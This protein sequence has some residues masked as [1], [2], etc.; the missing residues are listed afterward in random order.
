MKKYGLIILLF[1]I[2]IVLVF[3][4][5]KPQ[6]FIKTGNLYISEIVASNSYTYKDEDGEYSDYIELYND[7]DFSIDLNGYYLTDNLYDIKKWAIGD[8]NIDAHEYLIIFASGKK[9]CDDK[10]MCHT[11]YKLKS[12]GE[13]ITLIDNTGN[14]ISRV[15]YP[16]M[17]NDISYSYSKKSYILTKPTPKEKNS[18]E[19]IK[20]IDI[21]KYQ[22]K[23]NE[24]MSHNKG[25]SYAKDGGYYDFIEIYNEGEEVNLLGLSLTDDEKDLNKFLLPEVILK[26]NDYL[27]IYLNDGITVEDVISANFKLSD[28]DK[29]LILSGSGR[30]IDQVDVVPLPKNVSYGL[31]DN[32]WYYFLTPT[33]GKKNN[34]KY[35]ERIGEYGNT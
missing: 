9:R 14:I 27:V 2:A 19:E 18:E 33:P 16:E 13:T 4:F 23:I 11:N 1:I 30:I 20:K 34:T 8:I 5:D 35:V 26:K 25:S 3:I 32:R 6:N 17:E 28:N 24:Y 10:L 29:K 7:N 15:T 22:L 12:S 31:V 21:N